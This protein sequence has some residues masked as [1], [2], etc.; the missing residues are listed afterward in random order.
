MILKE[1]CFLYICL[2]YVNNI[3]YMCIKIYKHK[4][5][6]IYI[7]FCE[8]YTNHMLCMI[9]LLKYA[10]KYRYIACLNKFAQHEFP[11]C[12]VST[13]IYHNYIHQIGFSSTFFR[14]KINNCVCMTFVPNAPPRCGLWRLVS[15]NAISGNFG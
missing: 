13:T 6:Y 7:Y 2:Y 11:Y 9:C 1:S 5:I 14:R 15:Q 12:I 3:S 10:C 4:Y 8:E